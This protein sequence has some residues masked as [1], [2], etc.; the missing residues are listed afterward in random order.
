MK[1]AQAKQ[2]APQPSGLAWK[3]AETFADQSDLCFNPEALSKL[4]PQLESA[5]SNMRNTADLLMALG[6]T[7]VSLCTQ[8]APTAMPNSLPT[9]HT[10]L[11]HIASREGVT[12]DQARVEVLM[13]AVYCT[14]IKVL[15]GY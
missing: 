9:I 1:A 5:S 2:S 13:L 15:R 4:A 8:A 3:I 6:S 11:A 7:M 10:E 14:A 12:L